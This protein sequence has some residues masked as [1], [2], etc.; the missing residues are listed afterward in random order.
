MLWPRLNARRALPMEIRIHTANTAIA[1]IKH[2]LI[3]V[4]RKWPRLKEKVASINEI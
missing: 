3:I 1:N 2:L 4:T